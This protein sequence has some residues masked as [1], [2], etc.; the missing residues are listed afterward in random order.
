MRGLWRDRLTRLKYYHTGLGATTVCYPESIRLESCHLTV[1]GTSLKVPTVISYDEKNML[2]GY[3]VGPFKEALRGIKLLL[4]DDQET[5][6]KPS[7][8]SKALLDK[9]DMDVVQVTGDYLR[10]IINYVKTTIERRLG[11]KAEDM[12]LRFILTV[13]A[14]WSDKAKHRTMTAAIKAGVPSED[15]SLIS[16]PEAAALYSLRSIQDH[17]ITVR[18]A[19][20]SR[21]HI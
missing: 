12:D 8:A 15:V 13:P 10:Q 18:H 2:W 16:E 6:Y 9:Y 20:V 1:I 14:V 3:Q 7:V 11:S 19:A 21:F 5:K 17:S 4:D